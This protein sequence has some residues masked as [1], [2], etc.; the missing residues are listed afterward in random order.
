MILSFSVEAKLT[1]PKKFVQIR[2]NLTDNF[3]QKKTETELRDFVKSGSPN[4]FVGS[5]GHEN[6]LDYLVNTIKKYDP[7]ANIE[8]QEF[9]PDFNAAIKLYQDDFDTEIKAKLSPKDKEYIKWKKFTDLMIEKLRGLEKKK[10]KGKNL[11]WTKVG[12]GKPE[13]LLIAGAH[14]DTILHNEVT[15]ELITEGE[16]PGADDNASGVAILLQL[17]S[18]F[19]QIE[20][21]RSL[22]IVF[23]DYEEI[24][25]LGSKAY[26]QK[27]KEDFRKQKS[28]LYFWT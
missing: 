16:M 22:K 6:A 28:S 14:Y 15:R 17:I 24:G 19:S 2:N 3:Q 21:E 10:I 20:L 4:R 9:T 26:V 12:K 8:I 13:E 23:F 1:T 5:V 27:Y 7:N 25:F 11:V 18:Y